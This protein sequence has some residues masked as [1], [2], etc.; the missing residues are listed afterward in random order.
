MAL[1]LTGNPTL[2][3]D[4]GTDSLMHSK[5]STIELYIQPNGFSFENSLIG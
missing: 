5:S 3:I 1:M 2:W 4:D